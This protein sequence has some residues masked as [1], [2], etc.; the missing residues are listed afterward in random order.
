[1]TLDSKQ[2]V[3][4]CSLSHLQGGVTSCP[5]P[6]GGM[7]NSSLAAEALCSPPLACR[8]SVQEE[9]PLHPQRAPS[10]A[11][12]PRVLRTHTSPNVETHNIST[13]VSWCLLIKHELLG[14][15]TSQ[16]C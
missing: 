1:M 14:N 10:A 4:C 15:C 6:A 9:D 5:T 7:C 12:L 11:P 8:V 3:L 16:L 2:T 13:G